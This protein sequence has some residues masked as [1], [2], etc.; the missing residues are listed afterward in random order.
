MAV[1]KSKCFVYYGPGN[2]KQEIMDI[3]CGSTDIILRVDVCGRCGTDKRLWEKT[4]PSVKTPIVL[5]HEL[6][7]EI[8]EIGKNVK[9]LRE[10]LSFTEGKT[11][12]TSNLFS[13][14]RVTVQSRIA[15]HDP[16]TGVMLMKAPHQILSFWI[17]AGY[18]QYMKIPEDM[19][20]AGAIIPIP[21]NVTNEE[22]ALVEPAAC[23]LESIF[24]TTHPYGMDEEGR[25]LFKGGIKKDGRTLIIGSGTLAMVYGQ[26][27][28]IEGAREVWFITRSQKKVD[29]IKKVVGDWCKFKIIPE[30]SDLPIDEKLELE[31]GIEK[32]FLELTNGELFDDVIL[33]APSKDAQRYMLTLM[34]PNGYAVAASFAGIREP[35]EKANVDLLHYRIGKFIGTSGC[36][37]KTME[38]IVKWLESGKLTMKGYTC[39]EKFSL[40]GS[41]E[42]FLTTSADGRKPMLYPWASSKNLFNELTDLKS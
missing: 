8:I 6:V 13:G 36:S 35:V 14:Q 39:P 27:A 24:S 9:L 41:A 16:E 4:H 31:L 22:A 5:G 29:L 1:Y 10:G 17:P 12:D 26:L 7:G 33:A 28:K 37:T 2:V 21:D 3:E 23:A 20:R 32:E 42:G 18:S 19:I 40:D 34:N 11:I 38:T 30:Y 25:H 15:R